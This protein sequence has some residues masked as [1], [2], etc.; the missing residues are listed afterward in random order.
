[1]TQ[2]NSTE[3]D[4]GATQADGSTTILDGAELS[5]SA[6]DPSYEQGDSILDTY[7]VESKAIESG[8]MGRVWRVRHTG[9]NVD[10][11]MKRPRA[12]HF[13]DEKSKLDFI[14]ECDTWI[15]LGLHPNIVSCYYV[16]LIDGIPTIFLRMD[17]RRRPRARDRRRRPLRRL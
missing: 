10:L 1:M 5:V 11:A 12:E 6:A 4:P 14:R 17:G 16:R 8:G 3:F 2:D 9:W 7:R 13:A 15:K